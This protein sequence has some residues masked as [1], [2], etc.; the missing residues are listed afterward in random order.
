MRIEFL[1]RK[2]IEVACDM[3]AYPVFEGEKP[4]SDPLVSLDKATRGIVAAVLDS[5]EFKTDLHHACVIHHP[6]G[7]KAGR[8][9]LIG[10]GKKEEFTLAMLRQVAGTAARAGRGAG[11]KSVAL[12]DRGDH[13]AGEAARGITQG[14]LYAK[15]DSDVQKTRD[16]D[17][18]AVDKFV[19]LSKQRMARAEAEA[20]IN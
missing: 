6:A 7:L 1:A 18:R 10:A 11:C 20:A 15:S 2:Y 3:L 13:D 5:G 8:L 14:F 16:K 12:L 4:D 19:M 9:L 17:E